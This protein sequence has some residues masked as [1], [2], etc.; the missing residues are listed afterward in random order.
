MVGRELQKIRP[1]GEDHQ[2]LVRGRE[3]VGRA[4]RHSNGKEIDDLKK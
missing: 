1:H 2:G 4:G 3:A